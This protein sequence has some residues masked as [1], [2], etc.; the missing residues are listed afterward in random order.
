M[1]AGARKVVTLYVQPEAFQREVAVAYDEPNG[2]V[3]AKVDVRVLEQSN[4]QVA[5]VGDGTGTLRPQL[6]GDGELS[7]PE[8]IALGAERHSRAARATRRP[9]RDRLGR[10][11][12]R[13]ERGAAPQPRALG[14]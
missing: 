11:Q 9:R 8:P 4:D 7:G 1:P 14:R 12:L 13:A 5:V 10:R 6:I 3:N 2:T